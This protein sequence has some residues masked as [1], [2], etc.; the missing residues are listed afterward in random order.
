MLTCY[1]AKIGKT[2]YRKRLG[3]GGRLGFTASGVAANGNLYF[4]SE[5]GEIYVVQA[6]PEFEL[7]ATNSMNAVCM[8]TPA[9]ARGLPFDQIEDRSAVGVGVF[10]RIEIG[11]EGGDQ[12]LGHLLLPLVH[13]DVGQVVESADLGVLDDL[14]GVDHLRQQQAPVLGQD[15]GAIFNLGS[16]WM[17]NTTVSGNFADN[18]GG[19]IV[20]WDGELNAYRTVFAD[21]TAGSSGGAIRNF[22]GGTVHLVESFLSANSASPSR[23]LRH[24]AT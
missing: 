12:L 22:L 8:A 4:T 1:D 13:L 15:G 21:N 3:S 17:N 24:S 7:L 5:A 23:G 9:I 2:I 20:N 19:G 11:L 18:L 14:V 6:G 16:L 10:R